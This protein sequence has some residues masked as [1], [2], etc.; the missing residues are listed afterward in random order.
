V[1]ARC[2]DLAGRAVHLWAVA[3]LALDG[4][5]GALSAGEAAARRDAIDPLARAARHALGAAC[6]P[7]GWP[8]A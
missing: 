4:D 2:I 8:P 1:P 3:D 5:G 6:S 7:D